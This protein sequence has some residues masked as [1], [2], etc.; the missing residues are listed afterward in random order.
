[1]RKKVVI[2]VFLL[3]CFSLLIACSQQRPAQQEIP[4]LITIGDEAEPMQSPEPAQ[5]SAPQ[6]EPEPL[7]GLTEPENR[8]ANSIIARKGEFYPSNKAG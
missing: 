3:V 7:K 6:V 4:S 8:Q 1:M 5:P 2:G